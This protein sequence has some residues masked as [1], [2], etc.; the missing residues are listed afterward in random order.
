[1]GNVRSALTIRE[2]KGRKSV[3]EGRA[4][5]QDSYCFCLGDVDST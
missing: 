3:I 1:M 2:T 5:S 4:P